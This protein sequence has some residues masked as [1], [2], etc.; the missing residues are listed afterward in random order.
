MNWLP[1]QGTLC[2]LEEY[3]IGVMNVAWESDQGSALF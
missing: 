2:I 1:Y 3:S